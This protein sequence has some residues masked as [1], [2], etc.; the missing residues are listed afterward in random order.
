MVAVS[1]FMVVILTTTPS[2]LTI[3]GGLNF[4]RRLL[5]T[6]LIG[7]TIATGVSLFILPITSRKNA[8]KAL[9]D[10]AGTVDG[11][12]NASNEICEGRFESPRP[13]GRRET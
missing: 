6:S 11:L 3:S 12:V 10:F 4:V 7:L 5:I 9:N 8:F 13:E 1:N 2:F